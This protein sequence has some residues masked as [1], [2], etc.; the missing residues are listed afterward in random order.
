MTFKVLTFSSTKIA[1]FFDLIIRATSKI[2]FLGPH[3]QNHV[4]APENF[5]A[6]PSQ[7]KGLT[8]KTGQKDIM[9]GI[10]LSI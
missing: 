1:G 3:I 4:H 7:T 5:S 10:F 8:W 6:Y 9:T 2:V